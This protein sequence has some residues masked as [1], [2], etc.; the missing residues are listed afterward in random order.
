MSH[1][2]QGECDRRQSATSISAGFPEHLPAGAQMSCRRQRGV[3][4]NL[5]LLD[6]TSVSPRALSLTGPVSAV[7]GGSNRWQPPAARQQGTAVTGHHATWPAC[8][9]AVDRLPWSNRSALLGET[10][11]REPK[12]KFALLRGRSQLSGGGFGVIDSPP[13]LH[14]L[15]FAVSLRAIHR[16]IRLPQKHRHVGLWATGRIVDHQA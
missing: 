12:N 8:Q 15:V 7:G 6:E 4:G 16:L 5:P 11:N 1:G 3:D 10:G 14:D 2:R 9:G 13:V